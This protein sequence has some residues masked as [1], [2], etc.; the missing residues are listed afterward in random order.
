MVVVVI[1]M[2]KVFLL[3]SLAEFLLKIPPNPILYIGSFSSQFL[4][5]GFYHRV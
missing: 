5:L 4:A 2:M 3:V 1:T